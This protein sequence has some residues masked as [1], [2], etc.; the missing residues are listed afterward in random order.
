MNYGSSVIA[1]DNHGSTPLHLA[2]K[3]GHQRATVSLFPPLLQ[4]MHTILLLQL[5]LLSSGAESNS[6]DH[7]GNTS[8]HLA[9]SYGHTEV[10]KYITLMDLYFLNIIV[11]REI[12]ACNCVFV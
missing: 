2:C 9:C 5:L 7:G 12:H 11:I 4:L 1:P 6:I 8:L 3:K 10:G